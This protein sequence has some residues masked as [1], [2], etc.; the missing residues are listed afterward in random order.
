MADLD[1]DVIEAQAKDR[2]LTEPSVG[3]VVVLLVAELRQYR[4]DYD[5]LWGSHRERGAERRSYRRRLQKLRR[6]IRLWADG[7]SEEILTDAF[8]ADDAIAKRFR[9]KQA[10]RR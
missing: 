3:Q 8:D 7:S 2:L 9:K 6:A 10:V 4:L 1:L 5:A